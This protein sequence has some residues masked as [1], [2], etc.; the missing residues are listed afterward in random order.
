MDF[1]FVSAEAISEDIYF[2]RE[3][4]GIKNITFYWG[5]VPDGVSMHLSAGGY[6]REDT[7]FTANFTYSCIDC[8]GSETIEEYAYLEIND[9]SLVGV[10]PT[11]SFEYFTGPFTYFGYNSNITIMGPYY[12]FRAADIKSLKILP[13]LH[14]HGD[15]TGKIY[16]SAREALSPFPSTMTSQSF[17]FTVNAVADQPLMTIPTTTISMNESALSPVTSTVISGL[18]A[19]LVD[20]VTTNGG[21]YLAVFFSN[22]PEDSK[23]S[24]G[25]PAGDGK[26]RTCI[27]I[28]PGRDNR[29][30]HEMFLFFV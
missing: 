9:A 5:P 23:F 30:S 12:R 11:G 14:W 13:R 6:L 19:R 8:D 27:M 1:L 15:I 3:S 21:E 26:F 16:M 2:R 18:S 25:A 17:S 28:W 22:V 20:N 29:Y 24:V 10:G 4:S 7:N